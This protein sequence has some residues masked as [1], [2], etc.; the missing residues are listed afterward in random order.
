MERKTSLHTIFQHSLISIKSCLCNQSRK[1]HQTSLVSSHAETAT[2]SPW[3]TTGFSDAE[4]CF[5]ILIQ[6]NV[7][8]KTNWRVKAIFSIGLHKKDIVLLEEIKSALGVGK[9]HKH[10]K[11]SVQYRVES[12]KELQVIMDHF[13]QYPLLSAKI[14]DYTLFKEAFNIIKLQ[15]HLTKEGLLKLV[16]IK[17]SLNL[18][19]PSNLKEAFPKVVQLN[20]PEYTF[21]GIAHPEWI[22]GFTSGDGS[23]NIKVSKFTTNKVGSRV[24]LRYAI[25][26]NIREKDLIKGLV[27]YFNLGNLNVPKDPEVQE[28]CDKYIY[29]W[30]ET[31]GFQVMNFSDVTDIIIPFFEKY[32]IR[33]QK[34]LDFE[35]FKKVVDIC[36]RKD[37][38]TPEGIRE[39]M[40][41]RLGMNRLR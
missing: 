5:S 23:F 24:Q 40:N 38:L 21:K 19:L 41:I 34:S 12:I 4:G 13:D 8:Y 37:H 36:K 26:L 10:G 27:T 17:A 3:F 20:R 25:G 31:V 16:A 22:A 9:I 35:D 32:R 18:G 2:L 33:G 28:T 15:E 11:D 29:V 1:I 39:I 6:H 30:K 7:K 14:A